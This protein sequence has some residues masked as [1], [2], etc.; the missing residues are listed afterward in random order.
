MSFDL[1]SD[2]K[3]FDRDKMQDAMKDSSVMKDMEDRMGV[4]SEQFQQMM[5]SNIV[6]Y[7]TA[8]EAEDGFV[9]NVNAL[10]IDQEMPSA[11][12]FQQQFES[13]GATDVQTEEASTDA[14]DGY[15]TTYTLA[16]QGVE[17]HGEAISIDTPD[18]VVV[19]TISTVDA[20]DTEALADGVVDSLAR[21]S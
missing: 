14:G 20:G 21:T 13:L 7:V 11:D 16:T 12:E 3:E 8:P 2:W 5:A 17:A 15:T 4:T 6:L 9:S 18:G 1:P 19:I 10:V